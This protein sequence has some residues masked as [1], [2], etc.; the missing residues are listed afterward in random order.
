MIY[1]NGEGQAELTCRHKFPDGTPAQFGCISNED[2]YM[3]LFIS[4]HNVKF[5][6][7][8]LS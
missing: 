7:L 6:I 1:E 3:V 2:Y 8:I 5:L 4:I